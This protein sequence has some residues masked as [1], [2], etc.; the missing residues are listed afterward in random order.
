MVKLK[1]AAMVFDMNICNYSCQCA[2]VM[3]N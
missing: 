2:Y 1:Y 3:L